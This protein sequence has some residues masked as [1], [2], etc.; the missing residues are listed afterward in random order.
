MRLSSSI[1]SVSMFASLIVATPA[2]AATITWEDSGVISAVSH[3]IN[4]TFPGLTVGTPWSIQLSFDPNGPSTPGFGST[5]GSPCN[6]YDAG[7]TTFTMGGSTYT[8]SGGLIWT[9]AVLPHVGCAGGSTPRGGIVFELGNTDPWTQEPGAWNLNQGILFFEYFET[10]QRDGTLP[11]VPSQGFDSFMTAIVPGLTFYNFNFDYPFPSF[12]AY[13]VSPTAV[14]EPG[15]FAMLSLG[16]A[17]GARHLRKHGRP[18][19]GAF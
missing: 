9:N 8:N 11:T 3:Q 5:A 18:V 13:P 16:L 7:P 10:V 14:P 2:R 12:Q 17:Y 19:A 1:I 4:F 15:T 6:I